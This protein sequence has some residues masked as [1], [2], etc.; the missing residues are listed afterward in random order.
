MMSE[1]VIDPLKHKVAIP[2]F[3]WKAILV[4][5]AA[6]GTLLSS[7]FVLFSDARNDHRYV[8]IS[9]YAND[10]NRDKEVDAILNGQIN[11][12]LRQQDKKLDEIAGDVKTLLRES[13]GTGR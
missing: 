5:L 7:Y 8:Q 1:N 3:A 11:E 6:S 12:R 4:V 2:S 13:R 9:T 10:R